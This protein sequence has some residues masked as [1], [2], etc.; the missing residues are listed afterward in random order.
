MYKLKVH[1]FILEI[2]TGKKTFPAVK[3]LAS[4]LYYLMCNLFI[5]KNYGEVKHKQYFLQ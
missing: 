4:S 5:L 2:T 3:S 1:R